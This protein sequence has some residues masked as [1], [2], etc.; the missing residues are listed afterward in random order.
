MFKRLLSLLPKGFLWRLSALN[1]MIIAA[2][3]LLSGLAIYETACFLADAMGNF[4]RPQQQRFNATL[5][6]YLLMFALLTFITGSLLHYY[7]TKKLI[8]PINHLIEATKQLKKGAYPAPAP[9]TAQGEVGELVTHFNALIRQLETNDENRQKI[10][11]DLSHELRTPITNLNGYLQAL[12]DG[13]MQGNYSLYEALHKETKHLMELTKQMEM[14]KE[15]GDMS[16][17]VYTE[18]SDV[19]IAELVHQ[20]ITVFQWKLEQKQMII[21]A[22]VESFEVSVHAKGIR[23]VINNLIENAI[24]YDQGN[25]SIRLTGQIEHGYY[26]LSISSPSEHIPAEDHDRIFERFY[27]ST[28]VQ[29]RQTNGSGLGLAIAKE[30]IEQHNGR[31]GLTTDEHNNTFWVTLPFSEQN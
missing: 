14:L 13:D 9:D 12:R 10:I 24:D 4:N 18:H 1:M 7:L 5:L 16:S 17:R 11:S 23:Q 8:K 27:R 6:Q 2:A 26:Y 19:D 21:D 22:H 15:W 20:C 28:D 25:D 31:I 29:N 3:I 30:I